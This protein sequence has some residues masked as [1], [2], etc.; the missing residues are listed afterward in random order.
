MRKGHGSKFRGQRCCHGNF[1]P[2]PQILWRKLARITT[3]LLNL[4][5]F[6]SSK[7]L[8]NQLT[9]SAKSVSCMTVLFHSVLL[10]SHV[11]KVRKWQHWNVTDQEIQLTFKHRHNLKQEHIASLA[12][13]L[14]YVRTST[15]N[16]RKLDKGL[17]MRLALLQIP[18]LCIVGDINPY[19]V[20]PSPC[21]NITCRQIRAVLTKL[22]RFSHARPTSAIKS[23]FLCVEVG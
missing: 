5:K 20:S 11:F 14:S 15:A 23:F 4:Q 6:S 9:Q 18:S 10:P 8:T 1:T 7:V 3:K 22:G 13:R 21:R 16:D 12:P 17:G 19:P 2:H